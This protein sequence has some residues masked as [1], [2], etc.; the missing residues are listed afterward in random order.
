MPRL[1]CLWS[2]SRQ[3]HKELQKFCVPE[4]EAAL[5]TLQVTQSQIQ[6]WPGPDWEDLEVKGEESG[7]LGSVGTVG[8]ESDCQPCGVQGGMSPCSY[9]DAAV[10]LECESNIGPK[11][12]IY[13]LRTAYFE[14]EA[15]ASRALQLCVLLTAIIE[16]RWFAQPCSVFS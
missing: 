12:T 16:V 9:R 6:A 4:L 14:N 2:L 15:T 11:R 10:A 8:L 3:A 13:L 1:L 5:D 7:K